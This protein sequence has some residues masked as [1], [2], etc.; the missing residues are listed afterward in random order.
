MTPNVEALDHSVATLA[1]V[2]GDAETDP[3][4]VYQAIADEALASFS[5][6]STGIWFPPEGQLEPTT[7]RAI[8]VAGDV[9]PDIFRLD[10]PIEGTIL[11]QVFTDRKP[12]VVGDF[13]APDT[14]A[15]SSTITQ[16]FNFRSAI[17]LPIRAGGLLTIVSDKPDNFSAAEV[18]L[19]E[20]FAALTSAACALSDR[21]AQVE[22]AR[23]MSELHDGAIQVLYGAMIEA[24]LGLE[25]ECLDDSKVHMSAMT[26]LVRE[27]LRELRESVL[28]MDAARKSL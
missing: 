13:R 23:L 17:V 6:S 1:A 14:P 27:G 18:A 11:G 4:A 12:F 9:S 15:V 16:V 26:D 10:I 22:R 25:A 3:V 2:V 7:L 24:E 5:A 21:A 19:A 28:A 8:V 20:S